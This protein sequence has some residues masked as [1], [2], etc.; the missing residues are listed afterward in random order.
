MAVTYN[1]ILRQIAQRA[2]MLRGETTPGLQTSYVTTPLTQA[3]LGDGPYPLRL[4]Q[5]V[6]LNA[7]EKLA[8]TIANV[9]GSSLRDYLASVTSALANG[10]TLPATDVNGAPI[11]GVWGGVFDSADTTFPLTPQPIEI[12]RRWR[13]LSTYLKQSLYYY[14]IVGNAIFHTRTNVVLRCCVYSRSAQD[15]IL[16]ANGNMLL[17][18]ALESAIVCGAV[19]LLAAVQGADTYGRYF[20]EVLTAI[21]NNTVLPPVA[22]M[23]QT[24]EAA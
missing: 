1:T 16:L 14:T 12:T 10:A 20:H 8:F 9:A 23:R 6:L 22:V 24:Q 3:E 11:I 7:E 17:P 13:S 19:S 2:G 18:D 4:L 5:D 15:T 21:Q